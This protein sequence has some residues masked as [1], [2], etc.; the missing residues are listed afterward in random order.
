MRHL[1]AVTFTVALSLSLAG[2]LAQAAELPTAEPESVGLSPKGLAKMTAAFQ[3]EVKAKRLPGAVIII[4]RQGKIG[5]QAAIGWRDPLKGTKMTADTIFRLY[6]MTKPIVSVAA[7]ILVEDG[8]LGLDDPVSKYLPAF[9]TQRIAVASA[10]PETGAAK[11]SVVAAHRPMTVRDLLRHTSGITYGF[12]GQGPAKA[13]YRKSGLL[14]RDLTNQEFA[15]EL[16]KLPLAYEPGTTWDYSRS[17]DVLGAVI[18]VAAGQTLG[19]FIKK[20]II[21]PLGMTDTAFHLADAAKHPRIAG[22][23]TTDNKIANVIP[24]T[25]PRTAYKM[26]AGGH[27]MVGTARDYA[28]FLQ[29]LLNGGTLDGK[30]ILKA[31]TVK[32]MTANQ[33]NTMIRPGRY[34]LPGKGYGFGLGFA[35]RIAKKSWIPGTPGDYWWGGAAGTYFWVDPKKQMFVVVMVQAPKRLYP[36]RIMARKLVYGGVME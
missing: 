30:R 12:F 7:M 16:A 35:V 19:A 22:A 18:E 3:A 29:M 6:S 33:L 36:V 23:L 2:P 24:M 8:K 32:A 27:G 10:D 26:Q 15:A 14:M 9:G 25:D 1:P 34:Y 31:S 13:A 20:R 17:T 28:R 5:Y 4:G 11:V 21:G